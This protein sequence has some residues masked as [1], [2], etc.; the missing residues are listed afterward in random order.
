[1]NHDYDDWLWDD[2]DYY[3][4]LKF[5]NKNCEMVKK[6]Y[7]EFD[8]VKEFLSTEARKIIK[9]KWNFSEK[10]TQAIIPSCLNSFHSNISGHS[11]L[12]SDEDVM[13]F[14]IEVVHFYGKTKDQE[15]KEMLSYL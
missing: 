14:F 15:I 8:N 11:Y 13:N 4:Q 6:Y 3:D 12:K 10:I 9:E 2:Y 1:M 7:T 5:D